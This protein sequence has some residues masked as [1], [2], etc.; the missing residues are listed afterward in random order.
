MART[1]ARTS[2]NPAR[3]GQRS[4]SA[5]Q[6]YETQYQSSGLH[7]RTVKD[8]GACTMLRGVPLLSSEG[9]AKLDNAAATHSLVFHVA[10]ALQD[11]QAQRQR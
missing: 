11:E 8:S 2:S 10:A 5:P 9:L 6:D 3:F 4:L 1:L 7:S